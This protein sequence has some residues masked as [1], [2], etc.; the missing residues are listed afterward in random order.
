MINRSCAP[1]LFFVPFFLVERT[2]IEVHFQGAIEFFHRITRDIHATF[3]TTNFR[4]TDSRNMY[5]ENNNSCKLQRTSIICKLFGKYLNWWIWNEFKFE[6]WISTFWEEYNF[7]RN[8]CKVSVICKLYKY[9]NRQ[10]DTANNYKTR[11]KEIK[12]EDTAKI[13]NSIIYKIHSLSLLL[14]PS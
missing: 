14:L 13:N 11:I 9:I 1:D 2:I 4:L 6:T 7:Y 10:I 3:H 5:Y 12:I 8:F